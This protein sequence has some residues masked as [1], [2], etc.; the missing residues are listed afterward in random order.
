M[1]QHYYYNQQQ[2]RPHNQHNNIPR[3][4]TYNPDVNNAYLPHNSVQRGNKRKDSFNENSHQKTKPKRNKTLGRHNPTKANFTQEDVEKALRV[5][6]EYLKDDNNV[7]LMVRL[8]DPEINKDIVQ[9]IHPAFKDISFA[10]CP[11]NARSF[12]VTLKVKQ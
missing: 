5:E 8:P 4:N 6:K 3:Q 10:L 2:F 7:A 1:Y 11:S 9:K 12:Y